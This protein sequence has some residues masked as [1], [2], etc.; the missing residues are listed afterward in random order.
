MVDFL[1]LDEAV[2]ELG[3]PELVK[4]DVEGYQ[5]KAVLGA[6]D[7]IAKRQTAFVMEL[8][9]PEKLERFG[10]TNADTVKP[11]LDAGYQGFWGGNH[12]DMDAVFQPIEAMEERLSLAVFIP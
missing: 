11:L 10:T 8:H 3:V 6:R 12:R 5:A 9:D 1:T 7:L 2:Q 4:I